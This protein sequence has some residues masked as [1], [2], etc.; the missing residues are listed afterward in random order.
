MNSTDQIFEEKILR[1]IPKEILVVSLILAIGTVFVFDL[2]TAVLLFIGG[3]IAAIS[4]IWLKK[5]ITRLLSLEKKKAVK[6]AVLFYGLRL[7][8]IIAVIFIIILFF[9]NK[10]L[11]FAAGFSAIIVVFLV[12]GV[13]A[14][15]KMM[16]WKN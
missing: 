12:E 5:S 3:A 13:V 2:I 7:I 10:V 15:S 8:L 16:R 9:Q 14:V 1:R 6:S 4:F 11:A